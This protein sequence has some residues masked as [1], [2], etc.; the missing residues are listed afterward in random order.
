MVQMNGY[1]FQFLGRGV[2]YQNGYVF[3]VVF[4]VQFG[5]QFIV[6]LEN[7]FSSLVFS[8]GIGRGSRVINGKLIKCYWEYI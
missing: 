4:M 5:F 2:V 8:V 6:R 1:L 3:Y 7:Q